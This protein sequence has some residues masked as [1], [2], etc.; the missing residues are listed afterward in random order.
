MRFAA[1]TMSYSFAGVVLQTKLVD[2]LKAISLS[3]H[4]YRGFHPA[5]RETRN[6]LLGALHNDALLRAVRPAGTPVATNQRDSKLWGLLR[7]FIPRNDIRATASNYNPAFCAGLAGRAAD[8]LGVGP[9][10]AGH[11]SPL[12]EMIGRMPVLMEILL[13]IAVHRNRHGGRSHK[14]QKI[15]RLESRAEH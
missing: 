15:G 2:P 7:H 6:A 12:M 3:H 11:D 9:Y 1:L 5:S 8:P 10:S 4:A 13:P 14:S